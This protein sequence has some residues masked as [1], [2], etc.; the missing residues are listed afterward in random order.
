MV[1]VSNEI[2]LKLKLLSGSAIPIDGYELEPLT[3]RDI[4][5]MSHDTYMTAITFLTADIQ[6]FINFDV[7]SE[8]EKKNAEKITVFDVA[9]VRK[10]ML[11]DSLTEYIKI[12][13]KDGMVFDESTYS[14][15]S[16]KGQINSA[17]FRQLQDTIKLQNMLSSVYGEEKFNPKNDAAA[18]IIEK[19]KKSRKKLAEA[20]NND[21]KDKEIDLADIISAVSAKSNSI[22]KFNIWDL[23]IYQLYDEFRRLRT[24]DEYYLAIEAIRN[25]AKDIEIHHW[26][27]RFKDNS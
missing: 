1:D 18:R 16:L 13:T 5:N 6:S 3:L 7:L 10:D 20:K 17:N 11:L 25:G 26:A 27:E 2:N 14:F 24:I 12:V 8:E 23:T 15:N 4:T 22:N 21:N 19:L 9:V